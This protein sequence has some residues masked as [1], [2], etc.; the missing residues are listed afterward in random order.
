MAH[1]EASTSTTASP[2]S[3][4]TGPP[5]HGESALLG[6]PSRCRFGAEGDCLFSMS[7][8]STASPQGR[9]RPFRRPSEASSMQ[10]FVPIAL[11][12]LAS[13]FL[14]GRADAAE[15]LQNEQI[16]IAYVEPANPDFTHYYTGLKNRHVLE[17]LRAFLAPL[18]LP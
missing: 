10:R 8:R 18:K 5:E 9:F 4:P 14:S 1:S 15:E 6:A 11:L 3:R 17:E 2:R 16:E 7:F 12:G 13:L